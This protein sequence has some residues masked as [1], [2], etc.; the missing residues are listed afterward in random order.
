MADQ[1]LTI[2][3]STTVFELLNAYPEMEDKLIDLAPPFKKLRNPAL[4]KSVSKIATLKHIASVA[5]I[6]LTDLINMILVETGQV[7]STELF[8]D[9]EYF[10]EQPEWFSEDKITARIIEGETNDPDKMTVV[11][12]LR[13]INKIESGKIVELATSFLPAPGIET[14]KAKDYQVWVKKINSDSYKTYFLN[15]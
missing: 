1:S 12:V 3:P 4:K 7:K 14:M 15:K 8:E 11:A 13:E 2:R 10:I 6:P 9:A 5:G